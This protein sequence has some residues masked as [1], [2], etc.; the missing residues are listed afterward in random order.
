MPGIKIDQF[1]AAPERE[2]VII[3]YRDIFQTE[4]ALKHGKFSKEYQD[5][6]AVILLDPA[7]LKKIDAGDGCPVKISSEYGTVVALAKKSE[8]D[9]KHD[10]RANE[11]HQGHSGHSGVGYMPASVWL[12]VLGSKPV[13][14]KVSRSQQKISTVGELIP[15]FKV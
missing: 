13:S 8:G 14:A 4:A 15:G 10:V 9:T 2:I 11:G 5:L 6:S 3:G 7:D 12:N 1:L